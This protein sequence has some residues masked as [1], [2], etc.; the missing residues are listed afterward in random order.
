M[1]AA[2]RNIVS[3]YRPHVVRTTAHIW[4]PPAVVFKLAADVEDWPSLL[5]HYRGVQ[6]LRS[7]G[8]RR[9]VRMLASRDGFPV[10]WTSIQELN[11]AG[12]RIF[13]RHVAGITRGMDVLWLLT[14]TAEGVQVSITHRFQPAW[15]L[16]PSVLVDWVINRLFVD[17]IATKT[18]RC[19]R[20]L[21][22]SQESHPGDGITPVERSS[23][24][25]PQR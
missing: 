11:P 25:T 19:I 18:L 13:Y 12:G 8:S 21:A 3:D 7:R 24:H 1:Q 14:P 10:R 2:S 22:E 17:A 23:S 9:L 20:Q 16:V 6:V 5:P 4:A 15:P